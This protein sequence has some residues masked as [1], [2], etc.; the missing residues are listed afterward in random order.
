MPKPASFNSSEG[1]VEILSA[2]ASPPPNQPLTTKTKNC[3]IVV[4]Q[5]GQQFNT[6]LFQA[7]PD[8]LIYMRLNELDLSNDQGLEVN[9]YL[10]TLL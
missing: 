2:S 7:C 3:Q 8:L 5:L 9:F 6:V 4:R 1:A 10:K